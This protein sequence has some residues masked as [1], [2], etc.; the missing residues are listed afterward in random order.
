MQDGPVTKV[1]TDPSSP[2]RVIAAGAVIRVSD[3]GGRTFR[4]ARAGGP[5]MRVT[6]VVAARGGA[7]YASTGAFTDA[8]LLKGGRGVLRS[9]DGGRTWANVSGDLQNT[10]VTAL[11]A[12]PDGAWL[13][14][15]TQ[16]GGV[17]RL[18]LR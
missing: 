9:T 14:A 12:T 10:A 18:R 7:L 1:F 3:D 16:D 5:P 15:G 2:R 13:Y 11:T 8:G 4:E 6:D 17:H